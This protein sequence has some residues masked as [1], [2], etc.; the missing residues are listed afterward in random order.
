[1]KEYLKYNIIIVILMG[2]IY[3]SRGE[4]H[5]TE[6]DPAAALQ[7]QHVLILQTASIHINRDEER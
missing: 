7:K 3:P 2:Y 4:M 1:V 5:K 6:K